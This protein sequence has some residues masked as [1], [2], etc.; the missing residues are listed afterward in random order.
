MTPRSRLT[1]RILNDRHDLALH[2]VKREDDSFGIGYSVSP[3]LPEGDDAEASFLL[4][5]EAEDDLGNEYNHWGGA[6]GTSDDGTHTSGTVTAQPALPAA[7][8]RLKVRFTFLRGG[9]EYPYDVSLDACARFWL[10]LKPL[11]T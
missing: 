1:T 8:R 4:V 11:P 10:P 3:P 6:F 7:A 9:Q 5:L 2:G